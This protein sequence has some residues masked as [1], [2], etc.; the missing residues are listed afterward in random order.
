LIDYPKFSDLSA[1]N[2]LIDTAT[3]LQQQT[4]RFKVYKVELYKITPPCIF[5]VDTI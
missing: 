5:G 1:G 4:L 3:S 2:F